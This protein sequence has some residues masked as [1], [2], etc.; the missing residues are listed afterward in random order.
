[1]VDVILATMMIATELDIDMTQAM[2]R[3]MDRIAKK[4]NI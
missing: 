3:N 2:E 4:W 1:M